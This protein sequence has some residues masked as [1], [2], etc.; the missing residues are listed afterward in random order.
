M[1]RHLTRLA[2]AFAL[3]AMAVA[4]AWAQSGS[5]S[6]HGKLDLP[7]A[8]CHGPD[9]WKPARISATFRHEAFGLVLDGAHV[10]APCASCH[11]SL[12]F[13]AGTPAECAACHRD[14]HRG[15]L[16]SACARCHTTR[17]FI[18][19]AAMFRA[20]QQTRFPLEGPHA[21]VDC[22]TC[23]TPAPQG[24]LTW[25]NRPT[26]C[27]G[28]HLPEFRAATDPD[29][30]RAGFTQ[31]CTD[32]H[33][34]SSWAGGRFDHSA[35]Q[36]PLVSAHA[37]ATC[38][39]CHAEG[40]YQGTDRACLA[41]HQPDFDQADSPPH[42]AAGF[43]ADCTTCHKDGPTHWTGAEFDHGRTRFPL[44]GAHVPAAC[45]DCHGDGN[46][47]GKATTCA[48]CHLLA[49]DRTSAPP[50]AAAGFSADCASCHQTTRWLGATFDH[51]RTAFPLTGRHV[52]ATCTG[53]HAD[54]VYRGKATSCL[55]CHQADYDRA[56]T[57]NHRASGFPTDCTQCHSTGG[58][59]GANFNHGATAFPLDGSHRA[60]PC[61]ACHG[62]G[63]YRGKS[64]LCVSCHRTAYDQSA[65]P[66]HL[67]LTFPTDC[68]Q[69][70]T[71]SGWPGGTYD[72]ASTRFPLTGAHRATTCGQ[73][74]GDGVYRGKATT[75]AS[76][77]QA[78]YDRAT[79]P[80]HRTSGFPT[81]C[82]QCHT[83][84]G[85]S[86]ANFNHDAT[87]F[88][89]TGDH[90]TATCVSCH[91]DG[92]YRGKS[93]LCVSCHRTAYDQSARPPHLALTFPTDCRQ[94]H[95]T[96]GWPGGTYDHATTRFPL[97]GAHRATTC[98]Q[99]HGD[100]VYRGKAMTC[101][102]CHQADYDRTTTP[103][104]RTSG[105]P[106]D[107]TQCHATTGWS[108]ATF[109]HDATSFPLTG[110]HRATACTDCHGDGV[111]RG[112]STLCVS[113]HRSAYDQS[114][115]PPHLAL[116]FPT[117]CRQCHTTSGWPGGTYDHATT[118]FPLTGAHRATTCGQCHGDGVWRGKAMSCSSCH[119][120]DYDRTT[121]PNHR[122]AAFPASCETC[123][124]TTTWD[125]ATFDHDSRWFRIYSGKHLGRWTSCTT[126]HTNSGNYTVFTC[127][128][129]HEHN[130]TKMDDTHKERVGYRYDSQTCYS[131]H[132]NA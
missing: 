27:Q 89:L 16:G 15:E 22:E 25:V 17:A 94:C 29:H 108:G 96:S 76:C 57:P 63:V 109:N 38:A 32:C 116:T 41:C 71:T 98:G 129:C 44:T 5:G 82:T 61:L 103:N 91:G 59:T 119:Q 101:V 8:T 73:C 81:D 53:C 70:H 111:Y 45:K 9:G 43:P 31:R 127:L 106:T 83:T 36:F 48:S 131:C 35:T 33:S 62:D 72:H 113:C 20:H 6:P 40:L 24:G 7:C 56:T 87:A 26:E 42:A 12:D 121:D 10:T 97:T 130:Q 39:A 117:D 21:A 126:C 47:V 19:Q 80:N 120:A 110:A 14:V 118:R 78:D 105:F 122:T 114:A 37:Q 13:G 124:T 90:R 52:P 88:P 125:G 123:H 23:H 18:D 1:I 85:W 93:T 67:A 68:R 115:R 95:T 100:G 66:P 74:H 84:A 60:T 49:F 92:V 75:C 58:W 128:T 112:K 64:T 30:V 28:C 4:P 69:C 77:H 132:R 11:K 3:S 104:H 51:G 107:C 65:Q 54:R 86:G 55:S 102:S 50:H 99:C 2:A 46:W 79:T 34:G